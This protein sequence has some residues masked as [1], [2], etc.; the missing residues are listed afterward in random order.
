M[1]MSG[2]N[3]TLGLSLA[4]AGDFQIYADVPF[5]WGE[6]RGAPVQELGNPKIGLD[7]SFLR[8][9]DFDFWAELSAT[10]T[11]PSGRLAARYD[12]YRA[13]GELRFRR[14]RYFGTMGAGQRFRMNEQDKQVDVGNVSD[15]DFS[16]GYSLRRQWAVLGL[17]E[18]FRSEGVIAR[19]MVYA[20]PA[21]WAGVSPA[22]R[23]R[24]AGGFEILTAVTFPILHSR[25]E[26][27]MEVA[28]WDSTVPRV[29][30]VSLRTQVGVWF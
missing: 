1:G 17:L 21:E 3:Y 26:E 28:F 4:S 15:F 13:G 14:A 27:E 2:V 16:A 5:L 7:F 29:S 10:V 11:Q 9:G 6:T 12:T 8:T 22:I 23:Y 18:W 19:N 20:R 25:E 24:G 30:Q